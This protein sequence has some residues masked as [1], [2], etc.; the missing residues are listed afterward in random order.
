MSRK[1]TARSSLA[2]LK[3]DAKRWLKALRAGDVRARRR[4]TGPAI[5]L[6]APAS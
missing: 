4:R 3:K 2:T 1:L 6:A 5:T